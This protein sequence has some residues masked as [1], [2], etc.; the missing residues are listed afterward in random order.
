MGQN[1]RIYLTTILFCL[2]LLGTTHYFVDRYFPYRGQTLLDILAQPEEDMDPV[3]ARLIVE[4]QLDPSIS[5][6]R[7][8]FKIDSM[9][10]ELRTMYS[11]GAPDIEKFVAL[12]KYLYEAGEWNNFEPYSY[13]MADPLGKSKA[14]QYLSHYIFEKKGSCGSMPILVYALGRQVGLNMFMAIAPHHRYVQFRPSGTDYYFHFEAS[15]AKLFD[16]ENIHEKLDINEQAIANK[17]YLQPLTPKQTIADFVHFL[18]NANYDNLDFLSNLYLADLV[19]SLYPGFYQ[20]DI[21]RADA[22]LF[23]IHRFARK[24]G[25][26]DERVVFTLPRHAQMY[27]ANLHQFRSLNISAAESKGWRFWSPEEQA[28]YVR[29]LYAR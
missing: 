16:P 11:L 20:V 13:N 19:E 26:T 9:A 17:T 14:S 1:A 22:F 23:K 28:E 10:S 12:R 15:T 4:K 24:Y 18:A 5:I 3:L 2:F 25:F 29:E 21:L 8:L 7:V 6:N 27:Y